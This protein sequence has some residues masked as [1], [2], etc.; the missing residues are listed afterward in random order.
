MI[1]WLRVLMAG[2]GG[3]FA[4]IEISLAEC[5]RSARTQSESPLSIILTV[6]CVI[7]PSAL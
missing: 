6:G 3:L 1:S 2:F 5:L 7:T 4:K